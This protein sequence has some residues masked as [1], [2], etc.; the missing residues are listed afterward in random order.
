MG[1]EYIRRVHYYETD[2]MGVVHHS[3][4]LRLLENARLDWI[5]YHIM[6]YGEME[7]MG[8]IIPCLTATGNFRSYLRFDDPYQIR[9]RM[10]EFTGARM[11]FEYEVT[12]AETGVVCYTGESTHFFAT[13]GEYRPFSIRK[14]F[15]DLYRKFVE[16]AEK[17]KKE[18]TDHV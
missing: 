17:E 13:D 2:R 10:V 8:I 3:N 9:M 4:Y 7:K 14:S 5:G 18:E 16:I 15:P 12:N 11:R 1:W 6:R